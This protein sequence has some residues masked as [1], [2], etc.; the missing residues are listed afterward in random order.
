MVNIIRERQFRR[1]NQIAKIKEGLSKVYEKSPE[2]DFENFLYGIMSG[3]NL[4]KRTTQEYINIALFELGL[5][6]DKKEGI[7]SVR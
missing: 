4:S 6:F 3:L 1:K 2:L 5:K 7:L